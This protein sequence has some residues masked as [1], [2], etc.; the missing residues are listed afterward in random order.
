LWPRIK[1][2]TP[3]S[4]TVRKK[5][6]GAHPVFEEV[7][8]EAIVTFLLLC[9]LFIFYTPSLKN[10]RNEIIII[11]SPH[12]MHSALCENTSIMWLPVV[13]SRLYVQWQSVFVVTWAVCRLYKNVV[14]LIAYMCV[15]VCVFWGAF[16]WVVHTDFSLCLECL[17]RVPDLFFYAHYTHFY[18]NVMCLVLRSLAHFLCWWDTNCMWWKS[19]YKA[20]SLPQSLYIYHLLNY[21][22]VKFYKGYQIK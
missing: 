4:R 18:T 11:A 2:W 10:Y 9:P 3:S 5:R 12:S 13:T 19:N 16:P 7:P 14:L 8:V 15:C 21:C 22:S 1:L 17:F 20:V 6:V